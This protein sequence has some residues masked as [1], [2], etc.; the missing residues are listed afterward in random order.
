MA[1]VKL[2]AE[3]FEKEVL[4]SEKLV[5][6]DFYADWCGPCQMMGPVVEEISNEVNDA[7]VCKINIDEQM[8]IAQKYG[9]MS[10]PTFIVF[11]NGDVADKKMGAMPKSAVLSM[12]GQ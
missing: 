1:V 12:L 10:I 9:V 2:T 3:N 7:K 11:K 6:V 5:L 4:Q 8:S